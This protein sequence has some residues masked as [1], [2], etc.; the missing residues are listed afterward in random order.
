METSYASLVQHV[1]TPF[2]ASYEGWKLAKMGLAAYCSITFYASY[3]G[4]KRAF[5]EAAN[6]P[7]TTFLRFL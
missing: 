2:Y 1:Y 5:T 6:D 3:E 4:W 7:S